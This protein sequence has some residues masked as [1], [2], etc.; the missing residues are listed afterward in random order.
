MLA[1]IEELFSRRIPRIDRDVMYP[2]HKR[3]E[4]RRYLFDS[5]GRTFSLPFS[6]FVLFRTNIPTNAI[7][8]ASISTGVVAS[9]LFAGQYY[10][11]GAATLFLWIIL[12]CSD[13]ELSRL[14]HQ[15]FSAYGE[16][17]EQI[18]SNIQYALW[19]PALALGLYFGG[20]LAVEWVF[21]SFLAMSLYN[22][23]RGLYSVY[24]TEKLG[25]PKNPLLVFIAGQFKSSIEIRKHHFGVALVY[26]IWRNIM[27]Q[28]G[29]FGPL[30]LVLSILAYYFSYQ[31]LIY[32][33]I[34]YAI[35]YLAFSIVTLLAFLT[36]VIVKN[37]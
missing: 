22:V 11:L 31:G 24:P 32:F 37:I 28:G 27:T 29:I 10:V 18:N 14:R 8:V 2:E 12:D 13:G 25:E 34:L 20:W 30:L 35:G 1:K 6:Y 4:N 5:I 16:M 7:N 3:T 15:N 9:L 33:V 19:L 26:Y 17:L 21:A 23:V 36:F